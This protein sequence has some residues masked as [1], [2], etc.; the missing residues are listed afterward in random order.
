MSGKIQLSP[1][2][3]LSQSQEMSSLCEEFAAL[4][5]KNT[6]ILK[7][8]NDNWSSNLAANFAAKIQS[9]QRSGSA[10]VEM[11]GTGAKT[12]QNSAVGLADTDQSL[13]QTIQSYVSQGTA[14][15]SGASVFDHTTKGGLRFDLLGVESKI[16]DTR[17]GENIYS[18]YVGKVG[19]EDFAAYLLRAQGKTSTTET[20]G[21]KFKDNV[22]DRDLQHK[23]TDYITGKEGDVDYYEKEATFF[24]QKKEVRGSVSILSADYEGERMQAHASLGKA[25]AYAN[26][27]WGF[28]AYNSDGK[29]IFSPGVSAEVGASVSV[30]EADVSGQILGDE[31]AG[32]SGSAKVAA[33]KVSAKGGVHIGAIDGNGR[34]EANVE[35]SVEAVL[36]E[37]EASV[38]ADILGG[39]VGIKGGV[40]VGVGAHAE[41]GIKDGVIK[42]DLGVSLGLGASVEIELDV[43]GVID[44]AV[45]NIDK[46]GETASEAI[47][48]V[49]DTAEA[50]WD[51]GVDIAND[52]ADAIGDAAKSIGKGAKD[53]W[54]K[55]F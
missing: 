11:L 36:V 32:V 34:P 27:A 7:Q 23:E 39:G 43:G 31:M 1:E 49:A 18:A 50:V 47:D 12:A 10:I 5:Q 35:L 22:R 48:A 45:E 26:A 53:L 37:A 21:F 25:E 41:F 51:K 3:L 6:A 55:I 19:F 29:R 20:R 40:N 15:E 14:K 42:A 8:V 33:G 24:E 4:F 38:K 44:T 2:E 9:V 28:Y 16:R 52:A 17:L 54:N 30:F 46:I 13:I